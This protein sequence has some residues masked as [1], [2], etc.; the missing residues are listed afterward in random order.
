[1]PSQAPTITPTETLPT[2]P[3]PTPTFGTTNEPT[4]VPTQSDFVS[5]SPFSIQYILTSDSDTLPSQ[6]DY[7]EAGDLTLSYVE[8]FVLRAFDSTADAEIAEFIGKQIEN[9]E[10][11]LAIIYD[12]GVVFTRDSLSPPTSFS[13][14][15]LLTFAFRQPQ[16]NMLIELLS[17]SLE[18]ENPFSNT[19]NTVYTLDYS[20]A[21]PT[22]QEETQEPD[23]K[24]D[25]KLGDWTSKEQELRN[26]FAMSKDET[27]EESEEED[28]KNVLKSIFSN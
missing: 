13:L 24:S 22:S 3:T 2:R 14:D 21:I 26:I 15:L 6:A 18:P 17:S 23:S 11:P 28:S 7:T 27:Q 20:A 12:V 4:F 1:L 5:A 19:T 8:E 9:S 16:N 10:D 25:A